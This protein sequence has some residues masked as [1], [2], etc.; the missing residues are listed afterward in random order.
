MAK[1]ITTRAAIIGRRFALTPS[2]AA[3][4]DRLL[5]GPASAADLVEMLIGRNLASL[6]H[7]KTERSLV[8][9]ISMARAVLDGVAFIGALSVSGRWA[10]AYNR[11]P[12]KERIGARYAI[13]D[14]GAVTLKQACAAPVAM[15]A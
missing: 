10:E 15:V 4:I 9:Q 3:I 6:D 2:K 7:A 12:K 5:D 1:T 8:A 11:L 14:N 13:D